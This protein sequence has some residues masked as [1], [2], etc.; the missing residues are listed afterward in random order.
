M[1]IAKKPGAKKPGTKKAA[2]TNGAAKKSTTKGRAKPSPRKWPG[3]WITDPITGEKFRLLVNPPIRGGKIPLKDIRA[4]VRK[5][6]DE[7]LAR[8]KAAAESAHTE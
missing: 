3:V 5:V 4:A 2:G 6:R 7:R 8:E 1:A